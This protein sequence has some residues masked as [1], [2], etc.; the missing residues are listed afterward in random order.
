MTYSLSQHSERQNHSII[1]ADAKQL[2]MLL[3][4]EFETRS[5]A[6]VF[7]DMPPRCQW[8]QISVSVKARSFRLSW[9][10]L[11]AHCTLY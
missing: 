11:L 10:A 7:F 5:V 2:V 8:H 1:A 3:W 4:Q 9:N 6:V